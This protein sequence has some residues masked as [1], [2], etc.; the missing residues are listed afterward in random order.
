MM[1]GCPNCGGSGTQDQQVLR[2]FFDYVF[3]LTTIVAALGQAQQLL[4]I[5]QSS[6]FEWIWIVSSSL[7]LYSVQL[8]DN[9]TGRTLSSDFVDSENFAG[10][11]QLPFPLVEPYLL[12]RSGSV[13]ATFTDRSGVA[14][15]AIQLVLRGYKLF[16]V[17]AQQQGSSGIIVNAQQ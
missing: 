9:S 14:S 7:G 6:D 8:T 12:A 5:D 10:T 11:A 4:K 2:V 17:S 3:P 13:S 16:P 1:Q 15:N